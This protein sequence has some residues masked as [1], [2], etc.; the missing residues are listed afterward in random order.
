MRIAHDQSPLDETRS[1]TDWFA[2]YVKHQHE[3]KVA[4]LLDRAR[5]EVYLPQQQVTHQWKDRSK[6]LSLP[7]FPGYVFLRSDL[8]EKFKIL[9]TPGVFFLVES[10]GRACPIPDWE[11]ECIRRV[12]ESGVQTQHCDFPSAGD[13]VGI[14]RGPLAGVTGI[15]TR[16]K[17][18]YRVVVT[19]ELL[20]KALSVEVEIGNVERVERMARSESSHFKELRRTG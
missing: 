18:Q 8:K 17:N 6:K 20:R 3:N 1:E 19:V 14:I 15:L 4:L 2:A 5:I 7:L 13:R 11:M 16:F 9:N 10:A 12:A